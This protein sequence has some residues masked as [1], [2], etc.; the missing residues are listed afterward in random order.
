MALILSTLAFSYPEQA[1]SLISFLILDAESLHEICESYGVTAV[2]FL[3]LQR[4][5][6]AFES[7]SGSDASKIKKT[8]WSGMQRKGGTQAN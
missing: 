4:D 3:V 5:G 1:P 6:K 8:P 2:P 7:V